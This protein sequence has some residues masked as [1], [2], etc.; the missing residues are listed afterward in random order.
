MV[1][2]NEFDELLGLE[3]DVGGWNSLASTRL[4]NLQPVRSNSV[5][6]DSDI[7]FP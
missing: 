6:I 1:F 4:T 5:D 3:D 2:V 7:V